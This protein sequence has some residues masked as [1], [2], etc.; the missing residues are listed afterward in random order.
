M[1]IYIG[2]QHS[3]I[4]Q[5]ETSYGVLYYISHKCNISFI[6]AGDNLAKK[7][8]AQLYKGIVQVL[9][10]TDEVEYIGILVVAFKALFNIRKY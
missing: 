6:F 10:K 9:T 3:N 4:V 1:S 5:L 7:I 2:I 8:T